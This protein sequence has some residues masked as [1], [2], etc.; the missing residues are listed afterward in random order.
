M[1]EG[2]EHLFNQVPTRPDPQ[3]ACGANRCGQT[4]HIETIL[5]GLVHQN[6]SDLAIGCTLGS[7]P[8][9]ATARRVQTLTPWPSVAVDQIASFDLAAIVQDKGIGRFALD[10]QRTLMRVADVA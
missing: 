7:Q 3:Q 5:T 6:Q 1:L 8:G 9:I 10:E 2:A 4:E